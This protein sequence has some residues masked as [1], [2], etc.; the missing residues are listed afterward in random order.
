[1]WKSGQIVAGFPVPF[2]LHIAATLVV[3]VAGLVTH[4]NYSERT[5]RDWFI[6]LVTVAACAVAFPLAQMFCFGTT[7]YRRPADVAVVFGCGVRDDGMPTSALSDRINTGCEL[8]KQGLVKKLIFSGGPADKSESEPEV[9]RSEAIKQGVP[10]G[11]IILDDRGFDTQATVE[12]TTAKFKEL[13]A[14]KVLVVSHFYHLPR[15]K[16]A[17]H[18]AGVEVFTVPA[19]QQQLLRG[20]PKY[21]AREILALWFYFLRP[22]LEANQ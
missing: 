11:D 18:R 20:L 10:E 1:L 19:P 16:L 5:F 22:L 14:Q 8:Y 15:I 13:N 21:Q 9:M 3:I 12:N 2:S 7:D 4:S 6:A 17:Y